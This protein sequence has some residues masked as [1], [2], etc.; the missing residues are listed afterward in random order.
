MFRIDPTQVGIDERVKVAGLKTPIYQYQAFGVYWQMITSREMGG[1]FLAD[2]MGLGKT[3][4]FIAYMVVERQLSVL[5]MEVNNSREK[6]DGRHLPDGADEEAKC[7]GK[8]RP[9]GWIACPCEPSSPTSKLMYKEGLRMACVPTDLVGSW[10]GQWKAHV[11]TSDV[12]LGLRIVVDHPASFDNMKVED[13]SR[14]SNLKT[15]ERCRA[16]KYA[17]PMNRRD[18]NGDDTAKPYQDGILVLTTQIQAP[19]WIKKFE[20]QGRVRDD[21]KL[22]EWKTGRRIQL[23]FGIAMIDECHEDYLRNSGRNRVLFNLPSVNQP[24][25]WGYSGTPFSHTPRGI[26]GVLWAIEKH[27]PV[28]EEGKTG[29]QSDP[30]MLPFQ[31]SRLNNLSL[32]FDTQLRSDT[33]DDAA[34]QKV[35]DDFKPFLLKFMIRRTGASRWFKHP[36]VELNNHIHRD[37]QLR[38]NNPLYTPDQIAEFEG[39]FQSERDSVLAAQQERWDKFP[40][41][42][43][44]DV[45]PTQLAFGIQCQTEWRSRLLATFPY[46][47]RLS[48]EEA[49]ETVAEGHRLDLTINEIEAITSSEAKEKASGYSYY[50]RA[51]V[52]ASPKAMWLTDFICKL[53]N[54]KDVN[55][56]EEKLIILTNF[57]QVAYIVKLVRFPKHTSVINNPMLILVLPQFIERYIPDKKD[58]VG[59]IAGRMPLK[60]K[61]DIVDAF[62]DA[63]DLKGNRSTPANYQ[64]LVGTTRLIGLGLQL[65]RSCNVV[66]MEP[67]YLFANELQG[68]AR[69][70][71]IGQ[72]NPISYSYRLINSESEIEQRILR[73]Q[74]QRNE[75]PGVLVDEKEAPS[76]SAPPTDEADNEEVSLAIN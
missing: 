64:I 15:I 53:E 13:A 63:T 66:L 68:H 31:Y 55:G 46:L 26:E 30:K 4:S 73:R 34:V 10:F 48:T 57:P 7:P 70:H 54:Q 39:K 28:T 22:G 49:T 74:A 58:R 52:E 14:S 33:R 3:L 76:A 16:T 47:L 29:W 59:M 32:R 60:T 21:K 41:L 71:R 2:A 18:L 56:N 5:W 8:Q 6:K 62:T 40:A 67:D 50:L 75:F 36:L 23:V 42:R 37:I 9:E 61:N 69:V 43:R 17:N 35:L 19:L 12:E 38:H 51:I 25:L 27:A 65:T 11:D 24:F 45:R 44:S 72:K 20:A 1:G